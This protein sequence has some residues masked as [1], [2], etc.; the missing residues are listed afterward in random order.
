MRLMGMPSVCQSLR[1][2][3]MQALI[4]VVN[5]LLVLN[6]IGLITAC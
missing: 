1:S 2:R 3:D 6:A 4:Y 5:F